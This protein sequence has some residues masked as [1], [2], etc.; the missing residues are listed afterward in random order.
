MTA[1]RA[2]LRVATVAVILA[3]VGGCAV[4]EVMNQGLREGRESGLVTN[5]IYNKV[6]P[7]LERAW[8]YE[9]DGEPVSYTRRSF[10][11]PIGEHTIKVWPLD[12]APRSQQMVPDLARVRRENI[13]IESITIDVEP[14]YRY[15]LAAKTNIVRTRSTIVG[16]ETYSFK[17][18]KFIVPVVT[19]EAEPLDFVEGAKGMSVFFLSM[20]LPALVVPAAL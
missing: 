18:G 13:A 12:N 20:A 10:R 8:I 16:T 4:N 11:L 6:A 19:R 9:I 7:G 15:Y 1:I 14:G 3:H 2:C 5:T 17:G